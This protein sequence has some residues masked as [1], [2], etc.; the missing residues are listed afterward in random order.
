M[1]TSG[2]IPGFCKLLFFPEPL[3]RKALT[4]LHIFTMGLRSGE[5]AGRKRIWAPACAIKERV[6]SLLCGERLSMTTTSPGR[7]VAHKTWLT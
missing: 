3:R 2:P 7:R 1:G 6:G 5:E 4:L